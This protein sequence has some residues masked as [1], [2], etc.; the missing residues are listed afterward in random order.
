VNNPRILI[1]GDSFA[2]NWLVK[3]KNEYPGWPNLLAEKYSV[4]NLAQAGVS[5]YRIYQQ[6]LSVIN[7]DEYDL[8][9]VSHTSPYR[10]PTRK[11]P[12][13]N[14]DLLHSNADLIFS[15]IEYHNN[16]IK[17][18]FNFGLKSAYKFFLYHY[19]EAYFET[20][21]QLLR[22]RIN[23]MLKEKLVIVISNLPILKN[24]TTEKTVLEFTSDGGLINHG[25]ENLNKEILQEIIKTM[26]LLSI[27]NMEE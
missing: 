20:T 14:T 15:D 5:E 3:Y 21:Y 23:D 25:S 11:H 1:I 2:A 9:I 19:D 10:L 6:L 27:D 24:F 26:K 13:H 18:I 16:Q 12:V 7:L 4:T 8:V 17:N 22:E